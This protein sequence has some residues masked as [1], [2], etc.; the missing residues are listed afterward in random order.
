MAKPDV[1]TE[2]K[3][4]APSLIERALE[5]QA[6]SVREVR[7]LLDTTDADD[8]EH[9]KQAARDL[10]ERQTK[11]PLLPAFSCSLFL[12]N[13][14]ELQS[15]LYPYPKQPGQAGAY[16]LTIDEIDA[17]LEHCQRHEHPHL[18]LSS[19]GFWPALI[20]P[21]LEK[22][23]LLKT[24]GN[25]FN[26]IRE[27]SP[28]LVLSGF[29]P[30]EVEFLSIVSDRNPGYILE[31]LKDH[32]L[33]ALCGYQTGLLV[34]SVRQKISPKL[35]T[36]KDWLKIV[37]LAA[38]LGLPSWL[39]TELGHMETQQ[40]RAE[41]LLGVRNFLQQE[42]ERSETPIFAGLAPILLKNNPR[43]QPQWPGHK[44]TS[45]RDREKWLALSRLLLGWWIPVQQPFW[46][47]DASDPL[48]EAMEGLT[49]G[50]NTLGDTDVLAHPSFLLDVH[51][52]N[53]LFPPYT[54][55]ELRQAQAQVF[56]I[57][58]QKQ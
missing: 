5:G 21:G 22:P 49:W 48:D 34:N 3:L 56:D 55:T 46:M 38:K 9:L 47:A 12:T 51:P 57:P 13:L 32:G 58:G 45:V 31:F 52:K 19:G 53:R 37:R 50:A 14:C 4:H 26:H 6:L 23:T 39:F 25:L 35:Q 10:A 28:G 27:K 33:T 36:V 42:A 20:I 8:L 17:V 24:W 30:D 40:D 7:H 18:R 16:T 44:I 29:S 43:T 54:Q 41:H 15:T 2:K 11:T 1:F